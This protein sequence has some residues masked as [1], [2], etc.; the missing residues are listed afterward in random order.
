MV[1]NKYIQDTSQIY[2]ILLIIAMQ[3]YHSWYTHYIIVI[4]ISRFH[5]MTDHVLT[6]DY[7]SFLVKK[8]KT[9]CGPNSSISTFFFFSSIFIS[10]LVQ[11]RRI[12]EKKN[13]GRK[14]GVN[15]SVLHTFLWGKKLNVVRDTVSHCY[16][17]YK[18]VIWGQ[19]QSACPET[20]R[21]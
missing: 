6:F 3:N 14:D 4:F 13:N 7:K 1:I 9:Y 12:W 16:R 2:D 15:V 5:I 10:I 21:I 11:Y 19:L 20:N 8:K 17:K 18:R